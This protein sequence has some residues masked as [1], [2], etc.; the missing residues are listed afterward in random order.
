MTTPLAEQS[1]KLKPAAAAAAGLSD[2]GSHE[3]IPPAPSAVSTSSKRGIWGWLFLAALAAAAWYFSPHW[4]PRV[5]ALLH[6]APPPAP[7]GPRAVPVVTTK[8]LERDFHLY[9][10]GLGT[11]TAFNTVTVKTRVE[12]EVVNVAFTEGQMVQAGDLLA[13]IDPRTYQMQRDQVQAQIA[14][15]EATLKLAESTLLRQNDLMKSQATTPQIVDQQ[16][17]QVDQAR[18]ALQMDQAMLETANLQLIY[19]RI[20][21]PISGRIGLRLVDRGNIVQANSPLGLAV[22]TQL[23][24]ISLVFTIPQDDIPRVQKRIAEKGELTVEAFDRDFRTRLAVGKLTAIDNQVDATTGTLRLKATFDNKDHALFPNQF[25]NARLEVETLPNALLIPSAALQ[26]GPESTYVY[27][28]KSDDTV[29]LRTV[30]LGPSEG[31]E[32]AILHG[33]AAGETIVTNGL[34]KLQPGAKVI[35]REKTGPG[36]GERPAS[37][38]EAPA[39]ARK[40]AA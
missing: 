22:I 12:G 5:E 36:R 30:Q 21:A 13:E 3:A 26:R 7:A 25:V 27:V 23:E 19:C 14:R 15:D 40:G 16:V 6:A 33:L 2:R 38:G 24:P 39:A 32:T 1:S 37:P 28:V 10:N 11:V 20:V 17:A 9:I 29:E 8:V 4:W 35:L 31:A 18:A 34:D